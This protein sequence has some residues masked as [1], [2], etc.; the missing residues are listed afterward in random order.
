MASFESREEL[1]DHL[2]NHRAC[3][4]LLKLGDLS[5]IWVALVSVSP[6]TSQDYSVSLSICLFS[7]TPQSHRLAKDRDAL[8]PGRDLLPLYVGKNTYFCI[9]IYMFLDLIVR[10]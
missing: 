3:L 6:C 4:A 8:F 9:C 10:L 5:V 2:L 1:S 7:L